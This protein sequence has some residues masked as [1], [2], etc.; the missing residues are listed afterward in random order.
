MQKK[1]ITLPDGR[2]LIY[3]EFEDSRRQPVASHQDEK[4][5]VDK[6]VSDRA[7]DWP[8]KTGDSHE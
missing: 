4:G 6:A 8:L 3:Y 7:G 5:A 2:Y 1:R